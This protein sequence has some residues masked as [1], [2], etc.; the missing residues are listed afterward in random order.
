MSGIGH[1]AAS[2]LGTSWSHDPLAHAISATGPMTG[3]YATCGFYAPKGV[4][5][6]QRSPDEMSLPKGRLH[7]TWQ[8]LQKRNP[9]TIT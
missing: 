3:P 4:L 6:A 9:P 5:P 2:D 1:G 8:S 7:R